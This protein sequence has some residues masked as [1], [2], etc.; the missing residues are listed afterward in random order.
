MIPNIE[1][2]CVR[3]DQTVRDAIACIDRNQRGIALVVDEDNRLRGTVVDGDVRRALLAGFEIDRPVSELLARKARSAYARPTTARVG[4]PPTR[5]LAIMRRAKIRQLP[6]VGSD[7]RLA[8]LVT[9]ED[10][11]PETEQPMQAVI[12]A[13]GLG[14]RLRPLT[15]T[16]PKPMLPVGDKPI[17]EHII[18]QLRAA[19]IRQVNV[20][21]NYLGEQ[22]REYFQDGSPFGMRLNYVA[23]D[24]PLGTA[25]AISLFSPSSEPILIINGDILTQ[26]DFRAM[27]AYHREH[28]AELTVA[29]RRYDFQVPYGVVTTDGPLVREIVEKP[30]QSFFVNAGIYLLEPSAHGLIPRGEPFDMTDLIAR[31]VQEKR[32]VAGFPVWEY[33]IDVGRQDDYERAQADSASRGDP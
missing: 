7:G 29:L 14:L 23:E 5:L 1:A 11:L 21:T 16:V 4:T 25:G 33:W 2:F 20:T 22:I 24:R 10:L 15:E 27:L 17:M 26:V 13:G 8:D 19:G 28:E 9:I 3:P 31:L 6:L 18:D 30:V 12:M 32:T